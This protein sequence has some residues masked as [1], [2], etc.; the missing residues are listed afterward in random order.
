MTLLS[1]IMP[2]YNKEEYIDRAIQSIIGQNFKEWELIIVDDGSIDK[3][4][5]L[6]KKY[7]NEKIKVISIE[8]NG[9][10]NARNIGLNMSCGDFVTFIDADDY[11]A[12][13]YLENLYQ[14]QYERRRHHSLSGKLRQHHL[15]PERQSLHTV[16]ESHIPHSRPQSAACL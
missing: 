15:F 10:S 6:C 1:I 11:V 12:S 3:S 2:V 5:S 7:E 13:D 14:P 9:V 4:L 16:P 8:N